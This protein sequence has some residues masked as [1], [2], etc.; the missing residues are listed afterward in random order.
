MTF[1]NANNA[2]LNLQ[3]QLRGGMFL[4]SDVKD[5]IKKQWTTMVQRELAQDLLMRQFCTT[6]SFADGKKGDRII[7]PTLGR[8]GVNRKV[9][10]QPVFLQKTTTDT[11]S[12]TVDQYKEVSFN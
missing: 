6:I 5:W 2:T 8:L 3:A 9:A 1:S 4:K 11:W 10:G 12:I 7:V